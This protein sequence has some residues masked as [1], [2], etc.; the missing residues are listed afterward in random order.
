MGVNEK[1]FQSFGHKTR[2]EGAT[3][4]ILAQMGE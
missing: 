2:K 3:L 4:N 1:Y